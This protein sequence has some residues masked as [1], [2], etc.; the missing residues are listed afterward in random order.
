[1]LDFAIDLAR[2]AGALLRD[3]LEQ[4]RTIAL[5][6]RFDLVTDMDRASEKLIVSAISARFPHHAIQA[7]EGTGT[8]GS[9][10]LTWLIDPLDGTNNYAHGFP[11]FCVSLALWQGRTPV[12][13]V[14]YSPLMDEMFSAEAGYGARRND[15]PIHVSSIAKIES[16]LLSTGFPY[17]Y[18]TTTDN[19]LHEFDRV[20]S[21]C[22]GVR[23]A[24]AAALD[25]AYLAMG[26]LD[27]HWERG[28]QPWDSGAGSL[29]VLEAGG[30]IS[31]WDGAPWHPWSNQLLASNGLIH[32]EMMHVINNE[33]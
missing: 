22:Q 24:G 17:D 18:A 26:R 25:L 3:G 30:R 8:G 13:G 5:K 1:M 15:R 2:R 28:L 12:L 7:E 29:I 33:L 20:Q 31:G 16:A 9:G 21:R 4:E 11:F 32:D 27:A 14:V 10:E 23:R 19:N 6:G